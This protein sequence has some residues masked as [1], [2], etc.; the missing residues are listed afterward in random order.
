M[1]I[2]LFSRSWTPGTQHLK[3]R[4]LQAMAASCLDSIS[5]SPGPPRLSQ[6]LR[7]VYTMGQLLLPLGLAIVALS[8]GDLLAKMGVPVSCALVLLWAFREAPT[9]CQ[10]AGWVVAAL[11]LSAAGD[12]F[13]SN[14]GDREA[15]FITGIALFFGAHLG[16]L[17]FACRHG[18]FHRK[19]LGVLL[20]LY[21]TYYV[22]F[23]RPA[24]KH[25]GLALAV[26]LYLLISCV[27]L[28][29]A[30][31]MRVRPRLK[32]PYVT[33]MGLIVVS[34]TLISLKEFLGWGRWNWLILPTYYLAQ[35]CVSGAVLRQDPSEVGS[36]SQRAADA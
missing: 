13:L 17:A 1:G 36:R 18:Q 9:C 29:A 25:P 35:L 24:I 34:D 12:W 2:N 10:D 21:L 8:T 16:Y 33:G 6:H 19:I 32:W 7:V 15:Y 20:S 26:L 14:K 11:C 3:R 30:W 28:S 5:G 27:V 4:V 31:G 23:L 22:F